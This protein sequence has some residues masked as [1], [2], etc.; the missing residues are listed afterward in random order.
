MS[1]AAKSPSPPPS[2]P[3]STL[4]SLPCDFVFDDTLAI[5]NNADVKPD[6]SLVEMWRHDF[7]GKSLEKDDSH[8]SYR[9]LTVLS[10]RLHTLWT[11]EEAAPYYFHAINILLHSAATACALSR[12]PALVTKKARFARGI[13]LR[14]GLRRAPG[15]RRGRHRRRRPRRA[16]L[17]PLLL[18]R[19]RRLSSLRLVPPPLVGSD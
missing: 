7:W 12:R 8:K 16:P 18:C 11:R 14:F 13:A 3:P 1:A 5:V 2:P 9:P 17:H 6:A 4:S 19:R 15:P 10:F